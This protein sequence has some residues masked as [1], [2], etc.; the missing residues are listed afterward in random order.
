MHEA[1]AAGAL[2]RVELHGTLWSARNT[3]PTPLV[4]G[5]EAVVERAD[6]L[7][8]SVRAVDADEAAH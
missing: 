1:I 8:L 6:G 2:G 3:G 4:A 5:G 7:E